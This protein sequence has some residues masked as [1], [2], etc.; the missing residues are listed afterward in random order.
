MGCVYFV[1]ALGVWS[2]VEMKALPVL[3][4]GFVLCVDEKLY[5]ELERLCSAF[6]M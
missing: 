4:I 5:K 3:G 2:E 6:D 1:L